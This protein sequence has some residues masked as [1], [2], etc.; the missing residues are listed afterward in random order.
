MFANMKMNDAGQ[1][2]MDVDAKDFADAATRTLRGGLNKNPQHISINLR[3]KTNYIA[4]SMA[5]H[6]PN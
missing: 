2:V 3:K 1:I 6:C 4:N 5:V